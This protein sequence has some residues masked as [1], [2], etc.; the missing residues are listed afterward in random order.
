MTISSLPYYQR[1]LS[2]L[3]CPVNACKLLP[4]VIPSKH[5]CSFN[6]N[7]PIRS[8]NCTYVRPVNYRRFVRPVGALKPAL[9]V[10]SNKIACT[11]NCNKPVRPVNSSKLVRPV[12]SSTF[13]RP[14]DVRTVN[15]NKSLHPV[16]SGKSVR[17][18][19]VPR[20]ICPVS[21]KIKLYALL[22][23]INL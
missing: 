10:N 3:V 2:K 19:Y 14:V 7:K 20:P 18:V 23:L 9:S 12:N 16:N 6:F 5:V 15:S 11:V 13:V 8:V 17:L 1:N 21:S 4:P 22:I